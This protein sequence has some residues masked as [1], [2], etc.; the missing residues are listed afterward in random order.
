MISNNETL[1]CSLSEILILCKEIIRRSGVQGSIIDPGLDLRCV[2]TRKAPA[3][4]GLIQNL[5]PN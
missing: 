2:F 5:E 3:S 1:I 4:S